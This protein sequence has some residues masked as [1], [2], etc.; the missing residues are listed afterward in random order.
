[1]KRRDAKVG[2]RVL[3]LPGWERWAGTSGVIKTVFEGGRYIEVA[4]DERK[5]LM[6]RPDAVEFEDPVSALGRLGRRS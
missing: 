3:I 4:T 1:M 5:L 2:V 6:C